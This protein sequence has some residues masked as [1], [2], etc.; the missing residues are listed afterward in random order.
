MTRPS[1]LAPFPRQ[2]FDDDARQWTNVLGE[3][4]LFACLNARHRRKV[5]DLAR[6][7]RFHEG[8]AIIRLGDAAGAM[9]VVLDGEVAVEPP[10]RRA[11]RLGIGSFIG[12]LA[13]LDDGPRTATVTASTPVVALMISRPSFEKLLRTEPTIA[14]AIAQELA[15]RLRAAQSVN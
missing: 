5:A 15:R 10:G 8:E 9:Y 14:A 12:E 7:R 13:L 4:P 1:R 2:R 6:I 11:V 3:V